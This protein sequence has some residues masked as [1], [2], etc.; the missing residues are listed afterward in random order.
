MITGSGVVKGT[1]AP[2]TV[3]KLAGAE[4]VGMAGTPVVLMAGRMPL[5]GMVGVE[6]M[7]CLSRAASNAISTQGMS[8]L[9]ARLYSIHDI[10]LQ[11]ALRAFVAVSVFVVHV[12]LSVMAMALRHMPYFGETPAA[13]RSKL[14]NGSVHVRACNPMQVVIGL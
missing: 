9:G 11:K 12:E 7:G 5:M 6:L 4:V 10:H 14:V 1:G 2:M 3:D 13:R 8:T